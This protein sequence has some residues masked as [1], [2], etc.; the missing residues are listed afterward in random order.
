MY[1]SSFFN[2]KRP[3][4]TYYYFTD[5]YDGELHKQYLFDNYY[6]SDQVPFWRI[7]AKEENDDL[8]NYKYFYVVH[9]TNS[10]RK[11]DLECLFFGKKT[12][13][14]A[15]TTFI[16]YFPNANLTFCGMEQ[17]SVNIFET[18][19]NNAKNYKKPVISCKEDYEF[20][21]DSQIVDESYHNVAHGNFIYDFYK[22]MDNIYR[23]K[24]FISGNIDTL[25]N[26]SLDFDEFE[27]TKYS[28][29]MK[30][31]IKT[32]NDVFSLNTEHLYSKNSKFS[33]DRFANL[34]D[35][36][37]NYNLGKYSNITGKNMKKTKE[38]EAKIEKKLENHFEKPYEIDM[39]YARDFINFEIRK[40]AAFILKNISQEERKSLTK[41][42][43]VV[44]CLNLINKYRTDIFNNYGFSI[45]N[46]NIKKI[47]KEI[48][49]AINR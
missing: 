27:F 36:Q 41:K 20:L 13:R 10:E 33:S 7:F 47:L 30:S 42:D 9:V 39:E 6:Y 31:Q 14:E 40:I 1:L 4:G 48:L 29:N 46:N 25:H 23:P 16:N 3:S 24:Y 22:C 2:I 28:N 26:I 21:K 34:E 17:F 49:K 5:S 35:I 8:K 44:K 38:L 45:T 15:F 43:I 32:D 12:P 11:L 37:Q 19:F 18:V